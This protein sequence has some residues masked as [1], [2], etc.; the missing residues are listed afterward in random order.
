M[1]SCPQSTFLLKLRDGFQPSLPGAGHLHV[2]KWLRI[3][4]YGREDVKYQLAHAIPNVCEIMA[5]AAAGGHLHILDWATTR[6]GLTLGPHNFGIYSTHQDVLEW[7][8]AHGMNRHPQ[9]M[10]LVVQEGNL[11]LLR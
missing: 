8:D 11:S 1:I 7:A 4:Q 9:S 6:G 3:N 10:V 5:A 2:I